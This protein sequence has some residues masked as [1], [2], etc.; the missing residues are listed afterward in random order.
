MRVARLLPLN[1]NLSTVNEKGTGL[2]HQTSWTLCHC[3]LMVCLDV[4]RVRSKEYKKRALQNVPLVLAPGVDIGI[5][6]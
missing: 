3:K 6:V 2:A 1:I 5:S 4:F